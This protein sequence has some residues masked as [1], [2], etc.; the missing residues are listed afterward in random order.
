MVLTDKYYAMELEVGRLSC[1]MLRR[2]CGMLQRRRDPR[3]PD[4]CDTH[5]IL[6][7]SR[8]VEANMCLGVDGEEH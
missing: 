2:Y 4:G 3:L 1:S 8:G 5:D 7:L 6:V